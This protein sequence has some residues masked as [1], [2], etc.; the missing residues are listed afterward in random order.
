MSISMLA[1][2]RTWIGVDK[3]PIALPGKHVMAAERANS[4]QLCL[5]GA[6]ITLS[7]VH[8]GPRKDKRQHW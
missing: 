5:M 7:H 8:L 3:I 6:L 2:L 1:M 4:S